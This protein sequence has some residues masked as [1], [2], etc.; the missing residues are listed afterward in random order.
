MWEC[1][2]SGNNQ[3][4]SADGYY[5]IARIEAEA[6]DLGK[7]VAI[8]VYDPAFVQ[9]GDNC[10]DFLGA[11]R[12]A[13]AALGARYD[14]NT[15]ANNRTFCTGDHRINSVTYGAGFPTTTFTTFRP[16]ATPWQVGDNVPVNQ[17]GCNSAEGVGTFR[18]YGTRAGETAATL[19]AQVA[20]PGSYANQVFHRWVQI[21]RVSL[22]SLGVTAPGQYDIPI[23]VEAGAGSGHNRFA[24]R[25]ALINAS[26][27]VDGTRTSVFAFQH[28]PLYQNAEAA[29]SRFYLARVL[30]SGQNRLLA[31]QMFD[32]GDGSG[33]GSITI[34]P[35][36][37][38]T[39]TGCTGQRLPATLDLTFVNGCTLNNVNSA[40]YQAQRIAINVPIPSSYTCDVSDPL[41]CWVQVRFNWSAGVQ[42]TTTW[43]AGILGDPVRLIE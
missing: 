32:V 41:D 3:E 17:V 12:G 22:A 2:A 1:P 7:D 27:V 10:T 20:L 34:V 38:N 43:S 13:L 9:T 26:N 42:D 15:P 11:D 39:F 35:P 40:N 29:D 19:P 33:S 5:F 37:S 24:M 8:E 18:P 4:Y 14:S 21:C 25:S 16:D 6:G 30:P 31:I 28:L 36:G 23:Q